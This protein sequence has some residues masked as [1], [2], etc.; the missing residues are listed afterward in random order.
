MIENLKN[1]PRV[2]LV[3]EDRRVKLMTTYTPQFLGIPAVWTQEGG[4]R[5]IGEGIVIGFVDSG[6]N[7]DHPSFAY[8]PTTTTNYTPQHF[9]GACEEGPLFPETSCNGKIVSARFFSAGAQANAILNASVDILSPFDAVGHGS[10]VASIAAGNFGVP[11]VVNGLYYGRAAGMAPRARIAV[12]KAIYPSIGTLSDVLA[13]IDQ[14][15][16]TCTFHLSLHNSQRLQPSLS[17]HIFGKVKIT[18]SYRSKKLHYNS[19][20]VTKV[21]QIEYIINAKHG[22]TIAIKATTNQLKKDEKLQK[23]S[24]CS[25]LEIGYYRPPN[26]VSTIQIKDQDVRSTQ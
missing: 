1:A 21:F 22:A 3:E 7:P 25:G 5:N 11:V 6:I 12:Y 10:H 8:D 18:G 14:V 4:D 23:R 17:E 9:S 26:P 16:I 24:C 20:G 2:K 19:K 13:A 15:S